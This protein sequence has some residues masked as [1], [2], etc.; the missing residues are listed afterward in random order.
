MLISS[1]RAPGDRA[2][3]LLAYNL[4]LGPAMWQ[5]KQDTYTAVYYSTYDRCLMICPDPFEDQR[6]EK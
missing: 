1:S 4:L 2:H 6:L 3:T 5:T